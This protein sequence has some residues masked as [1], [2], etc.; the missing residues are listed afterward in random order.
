MNKGKVDP[1]MTEGAYSLGKVVNSESPSKGVP[2]LT[3][4]GS[5]VVAALLE[6]ILGPRVACAGMT[7]VDDS[8]FP[9]YYDPPDC[10]EK[11]RVNVG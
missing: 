11:Y 2:K 5:C 7:V 4:C 1:R 9:I 3:S 10:P 8:G 6:S